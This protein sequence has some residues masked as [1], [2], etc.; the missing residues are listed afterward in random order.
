MHIRTVFLLT[1]LLRMLV[2]LYAS[3]EF[4]LPDSHVWFVRFSLD[5]RM[6]TLACGNRVGVVHVYDPHATA[7]NGLLQKLH[8]QKCKQAVGGC[9]V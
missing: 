2:S 6:T 1:C 3:Q 5:A 9:Q 8:A 7:G 4:P